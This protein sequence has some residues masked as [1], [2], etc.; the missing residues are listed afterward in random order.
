MKRMLAMALGLVG[1]MT[2][3]ATASAEDLR[4]FTCG[5]GLTFTL[6][7]NDDKKTGELTLAGQKPQAVTRE[8]GSAAEMFTGESVSFYSDGASVSLAY[9]KGAEQAGAECKKN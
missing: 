1:L 9:M 3:S 2:F 5:D 8:A 4:S 6:K 7:V